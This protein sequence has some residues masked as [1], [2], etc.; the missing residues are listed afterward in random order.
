MVIAAL[1]VS[2]GIT[3]MTYMQQTALQG[4]LVG[5]GA[6]TFG[7]MGGTTNSQES[8]SEYV[9][10]MVPCPQNSATMSYEPSFFMDVAHAQ[11]PAPTWPCTGQVFTNACSGS[12]TAAGVCGGTCKLAH[13]TCQIQKVPGQADAC[14]CLPTVP[15]GGCG[16]GGNS[17]SGTC[18]KDKAGRE[19]TCVL[20]LIG[21]PNDPDNL[22]CV[23]E[24]N[25]VVPCSWQNSVCPV[26]SARCP[27]GKT[28]QKTGNDCGCK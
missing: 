13:E 11:T 2:V 14:T 1:V 17:C 20:E 26:G 21:G 3:G 4:S 18:T 25:K 23:C 15:A 27:A 5:G 7:G 10:A 19:R 12:P 16:L 22:Q 24:T 28:C 6:G 8:G 9:S